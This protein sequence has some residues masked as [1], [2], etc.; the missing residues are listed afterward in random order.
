M[1]LKLTSD[2]LISKLNKS[3]YHLHQI[4]IMKQIGKENSD[5]EGKFSEVNVNNGLIFSVYI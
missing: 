5:D 3:F 4:L 1:Q 2:I